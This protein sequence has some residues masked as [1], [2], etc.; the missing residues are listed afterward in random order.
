MKKMNIVFL[1]ILAVCLLSCGGGGGGGG[2]GNGTAAPEAAVYDATGVW[3]LT[4]TFDH[5]WPA[6]YAAEVQCDEGMISYYLSRIN[7]DGNKVSMD[8]F[9][10][11]VRG[12]AYTFVLTET[13][14]SGVTVTM[15]ISF[16]LTSEK[17]YSGSLSIE[18]R[19]GSI[20]AGVIYKLE[21]GK[22]DPPTYSATGKWTITA[23]L[24]KQEGSGFSFDDQIP[25][26]FTIEQDG[27]DIKSMTDDKGHTYEGALSGSDYYASFT[28][29]QDVSNRL[30]VVCTFKLTS[31]KNLDGNIIAEWT[32]GTNNWK[33]EYYISWDRNWG[34]A[35]LIETDDIVT[36]VNPQIAFDPYG[37]GIAV[38][39]QSQILS[40]RYTYGSDWGTV[41]IIETG[42][43]NL[44]QI[45]I[46]P[47]GNAI[48]VWQQYDGTWWNIWA[49]RYNPLVGWGTAELIGTKDSI[50]SYQP[51]IAID[52]QGNAIAVWYQGNRPTY[53]IW[54]NRY[55]HG[56]GWG[57]AE[58]I[59]T[60]ETNYLN[61]PQMAVDSQGNAI[62]VW[63]KTDGT[64]D[65]IW[66]KRY[67]NGSGWG[68]A[69]LI[70]TDNA[71]D[72]NDPQVVID[73]QG[74]AF[75]IWHQWDNQ[76][77]NILATRYMSGSGWSEPISI[78]S[79]TLGGI[80]SYP[81]LAVDAKSNVV[82]VWGWADI[83]TNRYTPSSGW[84]ITEIINTE[85]SLGADKPQ[86]VVDTLGNALV[87]W[88]QPDNTIWYNR[89]LFD[90]GWT[91]ARIIK[92]GNSYFPIWPQIAI[93]PQGNA[94]AIWSQSD[95][96]RYSIWACRFE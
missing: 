16:T 55:T 30:T 73:Q 20:S 24:Q 27:N 7:Q 28:S 29:C 62:V 57:K 12:D 83:R 67:S 69:E 96:M 22:T 95:G 76:N 2:G 84:G 61:P 74:N 14:P 48:V 56:T 41:N 34:A 50:D 58:N 17:A 49:N 93:D 70:G 18:A 94:I 4:M 75:A 23:I 85:K 68:N 54:V 9:D 33:G 90:K 10:G 77:N 8:E 13:D 47:Q 43:G 3:L 65:R 40:N 59:E 45:A 15:T 79:D 88:T 80:D 42:T 87:V 25:G 71:V 66:A 44:P 64:R 91:K 36:A 35:Q 51:H 37:N 53:S 1:A 5:A 63:G 92:T 31:N 39:E 81:R 11:S 32:D 6:E 21:G 26:Y 60:Y 89:Y 86:V 38:W 46:D 78:G 52:S 82:A 19:K 72:A